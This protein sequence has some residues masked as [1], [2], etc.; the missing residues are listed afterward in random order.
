MIVFSNQ[1]IESLDD[2]RLLL[3]ETA[4]VSSFVDPLIHT[5]AG[6][7]SDTLLEV[8]LLSQKINTFV[9][10]IDFAK[11]PSLRTILF[12]TSTGIVGNLFSS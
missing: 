2:C 9:I 7:S 5:F 8:G 1:S 6:N 10:L 11:L 3:L 12:S 4:S